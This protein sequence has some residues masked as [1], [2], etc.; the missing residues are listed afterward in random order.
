[1]AALYPSLFHPFACVFGRAVLLFL[2]GIKNTLK[3]DFATA[4]GRRS[5]S[6]PTNMNNNGLFTNA[7]LSALS[8]FFILS[9][10]ENGNY[11]GKKEENVQPPL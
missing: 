3:H 11:E 7:S 2:L 4:T 10:N 8:F 9:V 1:M 5:H 6:G